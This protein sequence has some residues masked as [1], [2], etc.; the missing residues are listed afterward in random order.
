RHTRSKR[1]W[2]SDV[3]SSDLLFSSNNSLPS[4][5]TASPGT[6]SGLTS[7]ISA[8][9]CSY[10]SGL[11]TITLKSISECEGPQNSAHLPQYTPSS[12]ASIYKV[13][14][15]SG[16]TSNFPEMVGTQNECVTSAAIMF[17]YTLSP[18]GIYKS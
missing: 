13:L 15:F 1:D 12:Y 18:A 3:C 7:P 17:K 10:S 8:N 9:H 5:A 14:T 6:S 2:S 4:A 11:T 16:F